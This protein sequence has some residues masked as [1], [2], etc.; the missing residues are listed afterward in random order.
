MSIKINPYNSISDLYENRRDE[1]LRISDERKA[2]IYEEIPRIAEIDDEIAISNLRY[3]RAHL[4]KK[5]G[6]EKA[7]DINPLIEE[8]INLLTSAGYDK[9]YLKPIYTCEICKDTG[10]VDGE[11][12]SCFK[13]AMSELIY[14]RSNTDTLGIEKGF[15]DFSLDFYRDKCK[16]NEVHSPRENANAILN[17]SKK[18]VSERKAGSNKLMNLFFSGPA[19]LG[20]TFLSG[21]IAKELLESGI[22]VLYQ[23]SISLFRDLGDA[24]MSGKSDSYLLFIKDYV[25]DCDVLIIDDIGTEGA[26]SF[27]SSEFYN[28]INTRAQNKKSTIISTNLNLSELDS[29]Y[30]DRISS[31]IIENYHV[32]FF[33]GDNIRHLKK[34]MSFIK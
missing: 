26:N 5:E 25:Y 10:V 17:Y 19:G 33:Y 12:C 2:E 1:N 21:C 14:L 24:I 18:F 29:I 27:V 22:S 11:R 20:K 28:I 8:K 7:P 6:G 4:L 13:Q 32:C 9:D 23:S 30:S 31:R 34:G 16:D 3:A 15:S